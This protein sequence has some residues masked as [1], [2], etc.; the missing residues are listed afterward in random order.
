MHC[1]PVSDQGAGAGGGLGG[2]P[3]GCV[4][5]KP[6]KIRFQPVLSLQTGFDMFAGPGPTQQHI[7]THPH[8]R[9]FRLIWVFLT[10]ATESQNNNNMSCEA[11]TRVIKKKVVILGSR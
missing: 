9:W 2:E 3:G 1:H 4:L 5:C 6:V 7:M 11:V 10:W 8:P